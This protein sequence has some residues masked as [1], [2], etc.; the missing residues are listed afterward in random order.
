M[1][2]AFARIALTT[3]AV[4][5]LTFVA[6]APAQAFAT[7]PT[8]LVT[9]SPTT[10][11]APL[12]IN[13]ECSVGTDDFRL[14]GSLGDDPQQYD[15]AADVILN[16]G[17]G[18]L[19]GSV[20]IGELPA[21]SE[22]VLTLTCLAADS[23][24]I[25]TVVTPFTTN[26]FGAT[27][28]ASAAGLDAPI[29]VTGSCGTAPDTTIIYFRVD[30]DGEIAA[31]V[32]QQ[33]FTGSPF[34]VELAATPSQ[35]GAAVGSTINVLVGC[36]SVLSNDTPPQSIRQASFEVTAAAAALPATGADATTPAL[37]ALL[38]LVAGAAGLTFRRIRQAR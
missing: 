10:E 27:A 20:N 36:F 32:E 4:A 13:G 14:T 3:L 29:V 1:P 12:A 24:T 23:S 33:P 5:G 15:L 6:A 30:V 17:T 7:P 11:L 31:H 21:G 38:L 18:V 25:S 37:L 22:L 8:L 34:T 35:L 9:Q 26:D 19:T 28:E 16:T 2:N